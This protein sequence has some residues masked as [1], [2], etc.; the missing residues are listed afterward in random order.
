MESGISYYSRRGP[1]LIGV[2][3]ALLKIGDFKLDS[4]DYGRI[5]IFSSLD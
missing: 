5:E 4:S 3:C 2:F 1:A